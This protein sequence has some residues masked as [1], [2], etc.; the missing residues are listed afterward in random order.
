[1]SASA[2][3]LVS[4]L[5]LAPAA[6]AVA[7]PYPTKPIKAIT[8]VGPGGTS[9]IFIRLIG[10]ELHKRWGQPVIVEMRP[11]GNMTIGGRSCAEAAN[12]GYTICILPSETLSYAKLL[13]SRL[14]YE[15]E[16]FEPITNAFFNTQVLVVASSLGVRTLDELAALSKIER[17]RQ[18]SS[19]KRVKI[20]PKLECTPWGGQVEPVELTTY[21]A[22]SSS[23]VTGLL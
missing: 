12:D 1:M 19:F 9:D 21:R 14:P 16:K 17:Y 3:V 5:G 18:N 6:P 13:H 10:D 23:N 4:L 8:A 20:G 2:T 15:P 11:G 7:Q 22:C